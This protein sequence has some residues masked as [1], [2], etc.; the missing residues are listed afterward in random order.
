MRYRHFQGGLV[1]V[2]YIARHSETLEEYVVYRDM[3][4]PNTVLTQPKVKFFSTVSFGPFVDIPQ[5]SKEKDE[6]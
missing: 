4:D 5:F 1:D 3:K 2:L 6:T